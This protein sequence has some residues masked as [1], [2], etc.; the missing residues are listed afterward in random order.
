MQNTRTTESPDATSIAD[1][2]QQQD[3]GPPGSRPRRHRTALAC[4]ACRVRKSRCNGR[5]PR[6]TL[7]E[8]MGFECIYEM[9]NSSANLIVSKDIIAGL[10]SRLEALENNVRQHNEQLGAGGAGTINHFATPTSPQSYLALEPTDPP[11]GAVVVS[12]LNQE[13]D[14][15]TDANE[16]DGM[17]ISLVDDDDYGYFGPSSNISLMRNI[18]RAMARKGYVPEISSLSPTAPT[19][20]PG[21]KAGTGK[22]RPRTSVG[23]GSASRLDMINPNYLPPDNETQ[24]LVSQYFANT[25]MLFPYIHESSFIETYQQLRQRQFRVQ[26]RRT[27]LGLLNMILAMAT[28]AA[29]R[30][31]VDPHSSSTFMQSDAFYR[32][33]QELCKTQMLRG[34]TLE[35]VQYLLLTSQ[36]LQGTQKAV[37]TW[38][39]HGLAVKAALSIGLHSKIASSKLPLLQREMSK[40]TWYGCVILDRS[41][42][43]TYGRPSAIPEDYIKI[44]LPT[45]IPDDFGGGIGVAFYAATITLYKILWKIMG[46]LY[47]HNLACYEPSGTA[48]STQIHQL[49]DELN[50]WRQNLP[51]NLQLVSAFNIGDINR[52]VPHLERCR[53]VLTLRYLNTQSLLFRPLLTEMLK[54]DFESCQSQ[55]VSD[56]MQERLTQEC[57]QSAEEIISIIHS[58]LT[59]K[60][61]GNKFLGAWWFTTYYTFN[62]ALVVFGSLLIPSNELDMKLGNTVCVERGRDTL[63]KAIDALVCLDDGNALVDRC[64]AYIRQ[65]LRLVE[66]WI[67]TLTVANAGSPMSQ[68]LV[69]HTLA[70]EAT[71]NMS[72]GL[73]FQNDTEFRDEIEL[74]PF[75]HNE[76]QRWFA[77]TPWRNE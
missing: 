60:D 23:A 58:V 74:G 49:Q 29:G 56:Q 8:R 47:G 13:R 69:D 57:V 21:T 19:D 52:D 20:H 31:Q 68:V 14:L 61:L 3:S 67:A 33:A 65:L 51:I 7:C 17:A 40:R 12:V 55:D 63:R 5:R 62:A 22:Q 75:V 27:W 72:T 71:P 26:V 16:T 35:T 2:L 37:Q 59:Q 25:G 36:Y 39:T 24:A 46:D 66:E 43:M 4:N 9:P 53:F 73:L 44:D 41:L 32:R 48:L 54:D 1:N 30:G 34:T 45:P 70:D 77:A 76:F 38:N 6:C 11:T 64:V 10:E 50:E 15:Q 42:S 28:C 18:S